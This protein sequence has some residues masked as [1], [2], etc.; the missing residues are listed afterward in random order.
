LQASAPIV[1]WTR[2][3]EELASKQAW[4]IKKKKQPQP[5]HALSL[6]SWQNAATIQEQPAGKRTKD[7]V[8]S[9]NNFHFLKSPATPKFQLT[10][11]FP[12]IQ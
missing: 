8:S 6:L 12:P 5:G 10:L 3:T 7:L 4:T 1:L 9:K 11:S 2:A